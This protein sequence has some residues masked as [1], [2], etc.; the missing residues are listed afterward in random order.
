MQSDEKVLDILR[1]CEALKEGHFVLASGKHSGH[2]VQVG[3]LCQYPDKLETVLRETTK[4][5]ADLEF[6]TFVSAAI[7]GITVGQQLA[8]VHGKRH[9][10][11]ERKDNVMLLR[12]GFNFKPGEKV[13]LVEDVMTT[14]GTVKEIWKIVAAAGADIVGIFALVNRSATT[15]ERWEGTKFVR[16]I[17]LQFPVFEADQVPEALAAIPVS[18]PG[19]KKITEKA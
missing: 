13:V 12:R 8:L 16:A 11:C 19:S 15:E 10:F 2:Y 4:D 6:T 3:Q 9:V 14:G 18:R 5:F 7:G 1:E 17:N